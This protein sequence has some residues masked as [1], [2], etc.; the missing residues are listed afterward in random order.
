M[1]IIWMQTP[2]DSTRPESECRSE[3]I[4]HYRQLGFLYFGCDLITAGKSC[5]CMR[6]AAAGVSRT[7]SP[8]SCQQGTV[9]ALPHSAQ[10]YRSLLCAPAEPSISELSWVTTVTTLPWVRGL[11]ICLSAPNKM[12]KN[13]HVCT[14]MNNIRFCV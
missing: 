7:S 10:T 8:Q 12:K 3:C 14:F 11:T 1:L 13:C 4:H 2:S 6:R 5:N 9:I